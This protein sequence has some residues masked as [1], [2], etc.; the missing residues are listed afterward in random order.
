MEE[1]HSKISFK[2]EVYRKGIHLSSSVIPFTYI[3]LSRQVE[4]IILVLIVSE[5]IL[6]DILR[7]KNENFSRFYLKF[8]GPI[9]R[10]HEIDKNKY[11]FTGGTYLVMAFLICTI[12]FPKPVAVT[13]MFVAVFCDS[14]AAIVGK[15][16]GKHFISNKTLEGSVAFFLTGII[17]ILLTPKFT[18]AVT[19][20][21]LGFIAVFL[22]SVFELIPIKIDDNISTPLFFGLVYF[23][24]I[25]I[26]L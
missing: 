10:G 2:N 13:S 14:M 5:L 9:L 20:Y 18:D 21:Y 22:S 26:F 25:K 7:S 4:I 12:I 19:E 24:L 1:T 23:V 3:F 17:I 15:N 11:L 8:L 16:L 6:I